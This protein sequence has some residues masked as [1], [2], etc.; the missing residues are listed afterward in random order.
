M[1]SLMEPMNC[2]HGALMVYCDGNHINWSS[3]GISTRTIF[4]LPLHIITSKVVKSN[5][6]IIFMQMILS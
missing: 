3:T 1:T 5:D 6:F 2:A 4:N